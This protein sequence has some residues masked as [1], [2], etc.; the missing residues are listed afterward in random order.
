MT[1]RIGYNIHAQRVPDRDKLMKHLAKVRPAA[2][3]VMDGVQLAREIKAML[4][5]ATV[6]SRIY[7]DDDIQNRISP[8][9]WLDQR[10]PQAEGGIVQYTSNE[11]GF[12]PNL[13][14]WHIE[15]MEMAAKTRTPLIIGNMSV[16]TPGAE[17]WAAGKRL[18]ELLDQHRDLFILGLHEYAC[19]VITSGFLGGYPDNAGVAPNSGQQGRNLIPP[20]NWPS[21][22]EAA[23]MTMFHCGRFKFVVRYCASVGIKPPRIILTEHGFD[24]LDDI[25]GWANKL[26]MTPPYK[27]I[28]GWKSCANQWRKWYEP[29]GWSPQRAM[30]EQLAYADR[31]IYQGSVVEAQLIF[32]WGHTSDMWDQFDVAQ[33]DEFQGLMEG[34]AATPAQPPTFP[35][36]PAV[37]DP[38]WK[39]VVTQSTG[40]VN[41]RDLPDKSGNVIA[42]LKPG[43]EAFWM[44][45][46]AHGIWTPVKSVLLD[47][48]VRGWV[49]TDVVTFKDR[50]Q[51]LPGSTITLTREE[52]LAL[53]GQCRVVADSLTACETQSADTRKKLSALAEY[54]LGIV[55]RSE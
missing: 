43:S 19:G 24:D 23:L 51:T 22:A 20:A 26:Q 6:I 9:Q 17:D 36:L 18:L 44:P 30:F 45:N 21:P 40:N 38:N 29:L 31:T 1:S 49:S 7:P 10:G 50:P 28:R 25:E 48:P 33:A 8:K 11:A 4:P 39:P 35:Q 5:E 15:L 13:I 3:L 32:C 47:T 14:N 16:G 37:D 52:A 55:H 34:Y 27:D 53:D 2:V 46:W 54:V 12:S 41:V 42:L